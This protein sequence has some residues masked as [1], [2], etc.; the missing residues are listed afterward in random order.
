MTTAESIADSW[1]RVLF[2]EQVD[3]FEG[4]LA[5]Q[6][7]AELATDF[8]AAA[9][10][11]QKLDAAERSA[12]MTLLKIVIADTAS[13]VLGSLD[14]STTIEGIDEEFSVTYGG[15]DVTGE[16]Q[17]GFLAWIEDSGVFAK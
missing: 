6:N 11:F 3:R 2:K 17:D 12:L 16:L 1:G 15:N 8:A 14:G 5:G 7:P 9:R 13:I 4:I 10:I